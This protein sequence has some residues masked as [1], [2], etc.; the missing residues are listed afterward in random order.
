MPDG[1]RNRPTLRIDPAPNL[2]A[3]PMARVP[4]YATPS[5]SPRSRAPDRS[6]LTYCANRR[7][8]FR[9]FA[10]IDC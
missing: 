7:V 3:M 4:K 6:S 2:A 1:T 8:C 5:P 9:A 10:R